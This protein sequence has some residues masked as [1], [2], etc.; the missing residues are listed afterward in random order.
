[1]VNTLYIVRYTISAVKNFALLCTYVI[2]LSPNL[3]HCG[4]LQMS[5]GSSQWSTMQPIATYNIQLAIKSHT[6]IQDIAQPTIRVRTQTM[7]GPL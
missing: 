6:Y 5:L 7:Q 4:N 1:M 3:L 2:T